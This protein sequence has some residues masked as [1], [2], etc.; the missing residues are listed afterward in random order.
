[1]ETGPGTGPRGSPFTAVES[2]ELTLSLLGERHSSGCAGPSVKTHDQVEACQPASRTAKDLVYRDV[3]E[4]EIHADG[5]LR[6]ELE[7]D[8][9]LVATPKPD[10]TSWELR[11]R[12]FLLMCL[13][14]DGG[15]VGWINESPAR[16]ARSAH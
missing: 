4:A 16:R 13:P 2:E 14:G 10:R 11:D 9:V 5:T 15:V 6:L 3:V 7:G 12:D 8:V 1:M